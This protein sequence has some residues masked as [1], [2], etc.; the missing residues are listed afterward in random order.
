MLHPF[1]KEPP[2]DAEQFLI[3]QVEICRW[4]HSRMAPTSIPVRRADFV[5]ADCAEL[6]NASAEVAKL[7]D[8]LKKW[9]EALELEDNKIEAAHQLY[10]LFKRAVVSLLHFACHQ[11]FDGKIERIIV[12]NMP[13]SPDDFNSFRLLADAAAFIFMNACRSDRKVP[14]YTKMGGWANSFLGAGAGA[15]IGTLWE[16]RDKT[17][18]IFAETLYQALLLDDKPIGEA[19]ACA[20]MAVKEKAPG[21]PTW[22]AYAFYG[23]TDA[24]LRKISI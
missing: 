22:L 16:V 11:S 15:F 13:V 21:D 14:G 17:A 6:A 5:V 3:E 20:R 4:V 24:R 10:D 12:K 23:D 8:L 19:L 9:N 7:T 2:F 1:R 18:E